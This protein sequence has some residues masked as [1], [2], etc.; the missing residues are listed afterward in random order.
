MNTPL[1][2]IA[3]VAAPR[4]QPYSLQVFIPLFIVAA[5]LFLGAIGYIVF[6]L[7]TRRRKLRNEKDSKSLEQELES[8]TSHSSVTYCGTVQDSKEL[9]SRPPP[10]T[11]ETEIE[12]IAK[13]YARLSYDMFTPSPRMDIDIFSTN[14]SSSIFITR[15]HSLP[16]PSRALLYSPSPRRASIPAIWSNPRSRWAH[17]NR[18]DFQGE[19]RYQSCRPTTSPVQQPKRF[20]TS[21]IFRRSITPML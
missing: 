21:E 19:N 1:S 15:S 14:R 17:E 4:S 18:L 3:P 16:P 11:F 8:G 6:K 12:E 13:Y 2:L 5:L 10:I 9:K 20:V 7:F